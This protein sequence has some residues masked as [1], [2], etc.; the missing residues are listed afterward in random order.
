MSD[1]KNLWILWQLIQFKRTRNNCRDMWLSPQQ[2]KTKQSTT[3][4]LLF[5]FPKVS[6]VSAVILEQPS[7]SSPVEM[8]ASRISLSSFWVRFLI[9]GLTVF[10]LWVIY[11]R[12]ITEDSA[13][14]G[15]KEVRYVNIVRKECVLNFMD[16]F[17]FKRCHDWESNRKP[18]DFQ[19]N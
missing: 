6:C 8:V 17:K 12:L 7:Q 5:V 19:S 11:T 13:S 14:V 16:K 18:F 3:K 4:A 2:N 10:A 15:F 9:G 1:M